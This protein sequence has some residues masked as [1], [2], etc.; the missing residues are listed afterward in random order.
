MEGGQRVLSFET[1]GEGSTSSLHEFISFEINPLLDQGWVITDLSIER[2]VDGHEP[3][4][5]AVA[6]AAGP[7]RELAMP[8]SA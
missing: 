8:A 4:R 2:R 3:C 1:S 5:I 6:L 7:S